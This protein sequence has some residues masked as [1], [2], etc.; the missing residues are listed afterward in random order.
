MIAP[1]AGARGFLLSDACMEDLEKQ[2]QLV[3]T[4]F[5]VV[6]VSP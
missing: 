1:V 3:E 2:T 5:E 4:S 6:P